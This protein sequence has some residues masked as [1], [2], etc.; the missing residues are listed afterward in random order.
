ME[1]ERDANGWKVGCRKWSERTGIEVR[2]WGLGWEK[3]RESCKKPAELGGRGKYK[4]DMD[5]GMARWDE[6]AERG[7][8]ERGFGSGVCMEG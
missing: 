3:L 5:G 8:T 2:Q 1:R 4:K 6:W 7:R